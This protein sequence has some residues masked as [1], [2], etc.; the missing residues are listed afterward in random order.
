MKYL[1]KETIKVIVKRKIHPKD[2]HTYDSQNLIKP[3]HVH[4]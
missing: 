2:I 4:I 3:I 1:E